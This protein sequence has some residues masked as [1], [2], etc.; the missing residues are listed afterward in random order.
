[1]DVRCRQTV[2][3]RT[4]SRADFYSFT[5]VDHGIR[6][7]IY[8]RYIGKYTHVPYLNVYISNVEAAIYGCIV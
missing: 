7:Y 5:T 8:T 6:L 3:V 2:P 1:M 4:D